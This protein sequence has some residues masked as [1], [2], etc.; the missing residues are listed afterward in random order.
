MLACLQI[1][2]KWTAP[3]K[4]DPA[5]VREGLHQHAVRLREL[6]GHGRDREVR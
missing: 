4:N 6:A 3:A 1:G 5:V 2:G